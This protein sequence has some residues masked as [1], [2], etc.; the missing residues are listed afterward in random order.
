[1]SERIPIVIKDDEITS[2]V[3]RKRTAHV[4]PDQLIAHLDAGGWQFSRYVLDEHAQEWV[5]PAD[6]DDDEDPIR[7]VVPLPS[8]PDTADFEARMR[9]AIKF[10]AVVEGWVFT[11]GADLPEALRVE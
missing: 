7:V 8:L 2:T 5:F 11:A 6:Y 10:V 3:L 4:S 1:M 9:D